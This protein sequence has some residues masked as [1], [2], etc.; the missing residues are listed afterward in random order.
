MMRDNPDPVPTDDPREISRVCPACKGRGFLVLA[1]GPNGESA[2]CV[3]TRTTQDCGLCLGAR[4]I[5]RAH[6]IRLW[7]ELE[8]ER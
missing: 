7:R 4:E 8:A 5:T 6:T 2:H 3:G 1:I